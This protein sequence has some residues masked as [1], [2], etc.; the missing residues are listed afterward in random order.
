MRQ[1]VV[2]AE[3][4]A[5]RM[6]SP[7]PLMSVR[8]PTQT[9]KDKPCRLLIIRLDGDA[10]PAGRP[11]GDGVD[12]Y[13]KR[14]VGYEVSLSGTILYAHIMSASRAL[15]AKPRFTTED[16]RSDVAQFSR[17]PVMS[18]RTELISLFRY[19]FATMLLRLACSAGSLT[20]R[21]NTGCRAKLARLRKWKG[22][23]IEQSRRN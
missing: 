11:S 16:H 8:S 17:W 5:Q 9:H 21:S 13:T 14:K 12:G 19:L 4:H 18:S 6:A 7:I 2:R 20:V 22:G 15:H 1:G 10:R 3:S 23:Q